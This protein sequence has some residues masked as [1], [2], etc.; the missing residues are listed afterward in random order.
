MSVTTEE[1]TPVSISVSA[2]DPDG[3]A[4][5]FTATEPAHGTLSGTLPDATYTPDPDFSGDDSFAVQVSDGENS[6]VVMVDVTVTPVADAPAANDDTFA[7]R[8]DTDQLIPVVALLAND[9]DADGDTLT[10]TSVANVQHGTASLEDDFVA[11]SP[12]ANFVGDATFDYTVSD[13]DETATAT[14]TV[15]VGGQNDVPVATDDTVSTDEDTA[16]TISAATLLANDSDADGDTL[17]IDA[18]GN[19]DNGQVGMSGGDITFTPAANFSG[20]A[21]FDYTI[22]DGMATATATVTVTVNNVD[23]DPPVLGD[24][25]FTTDEDTPI[26]FTAADLLANDSDPDSDLFIV[27]IRS[28]ASASRSPGAESYQIGDL[29]LLDL[30]VDA[31]GRVT[32]ATYRPNPNANDDVVDGAGDVFYVTIS[33]GLLW[34]QTSTLTVHVTPVNDPPVTYGDSSS[35][36]LSPNYDVSQL[37]GGNPLP[38][39]WLGLDAED[40]ISATLGNFANADNCTPTLDP[41]SNTWNLTTGP[42]DGLCSFTYDMTDSDVAT[43]SDTFSIHVQSTPVCGD[44]ISHLSAEQCD[45]GNTIDGDGCSASCARERCG[46]NEVNN[47]RPAQV[48]AVLL[49]VLGTTP[50]GVR[51]SVNG[52]DGHQ[53]VNP[54]SGCNWSTEEYT[55]DLASAFVSG[56]NV[57]TVTP[58]TASAVSKIDVWLWVTDHWETVHL[59]DAG[60]PSCAHGGLDDPID[61]PYELGDLEE[62]CDGGGVDT[63]TCDADCTFAVCGDGYTNPNATVP[64]QCDDGGVDTA[65]CDADCTFVECGDGYCNAEAGEDSTWCSDCT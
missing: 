36:A 57:L 30:D 21:R 44:G 49:Q 10:V 24:D 55:S 48:Y 64:E 37:I 22:T 61:V 58:G 43:T 5:T 20:T 1:D 29:G 6:I 41:V 46:D 51:L 8:E 11:F 28:R 26:A 27:R 45:D 2:T 34:E 59:F 18:V 7:G 33:D 23:N 13:G 38:A 17:T 65:L 35:Q 63:A 9:S 16:V 3:D 50:T 14:V 52:T 31:F 47:R 12:A 40:G 4:L 60:D 54:T 62:E 53:I 15:R 19:A 25:A 32:G 39:W 56:E 42:S